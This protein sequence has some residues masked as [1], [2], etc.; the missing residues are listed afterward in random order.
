LN[1]VELF[2][3]RISDQDLKSALGELKMLDGT[4]ILSDGVLRRLSRELQTLPGLPISAHDA[5]HILQVGVLRIAAYKWAGI[6][7]FEDEPD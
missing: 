4:G 7:A 6:P 1:A 3:S 2:L 5:R